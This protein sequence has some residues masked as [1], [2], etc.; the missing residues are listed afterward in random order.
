V[1][2][3]IDELSDAD[4]ADV[5]AA[6]REVREAG[7]RGARHLQSEIWEVR[8][9]GD[10]SLIACFSQPRDPADRYFLRSSD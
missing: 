2:Q 3:F 4:A 5:L 7:L 1:E 9:D 8:V 10:R 6:M